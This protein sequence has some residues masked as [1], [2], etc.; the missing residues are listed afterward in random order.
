MDLA[1]VFREIRDFVNAPRRQYAIMQDRRA[2]FQLCASM[3]L[4]EDSQLAIDAYPGAT[5]DSDGALYLAVYGL[6]QAFFL[7]QDAVA[8]LGKAHGIPISEDQELKAV[9]EARNDI[10]GH[11]TMRRGKKKKKEAFTTHSISRWSL[12]TD[13]IEVYSSDEQA[14]S[15]YQRRFRISELI[16]EQRQGIVRALSAI[17]SELARREREHVAI[18]SGQPLTAIFPQTLGYT[19]SKIAEGIRT[20]GLHGLA[21]GNLETVTSILASFRDALAQRGELP[22]NEHLEYDLAQ[23]DY[24]LERLARYLDD[25]EGDLLSEAD[26]EI[27]RFYIERKFD[28]LIA[29]A[30]EIDEAYGENA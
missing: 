21:R 19:F 11:P 13:A 2:W 7:Q 4:V 29:I 6:L 10:V 18:F 14:S 5:S 16:E 1:D 15:L 8:H 30:K 23:L 17:Q 24:P 9:R 25:P 27:Y 22:A 20:A 26:A 12:S 28:D 3:D